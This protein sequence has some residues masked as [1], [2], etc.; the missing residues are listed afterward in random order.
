MAGRINRGAAWARKRRQGH[1]SNL[2]HLE[3]ESTV[4]LLTYA[5][6]RHLS[7]ANDLE[8][9]RA[10]IVAGLTGATCDS[11]MCAL[12]RNPRAMRGFAAELSKL[13]DAVQEAVRGV[14]DEVGS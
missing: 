1:A 12:H 2:K 5:M 9:A 4:F 6:L 13:A 10:E 3:A 7:E 11:P 8:L 14:V